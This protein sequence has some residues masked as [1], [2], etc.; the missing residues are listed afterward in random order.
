MTNSP[1]PA[2]NL[3]LEQISQDACL[4]QCARALQKHIGPGKSFSV[5]QAS[6]ALDYDDRTLRNNMAGQDLPRLKT[7]IRMCALFPGFADDMLWLADL[8]HVKPLKSEKI[9]DLTLNRRVAD[10]QA[11][12]AHDLE[13]DG[14]VDHRERARLVPQVQVL[15]DVLS[16]WVA[17]AMAQQVGHGL[18]EN[19]HSLHGSKVA[20]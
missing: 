2:R 9:P 4:K 19:V 11:L 8:G 6:A 10:L 7:F 17:H 18:A 1:V 14:H 20:A 12:L 15:I 16:R 13:T 5:A 3:Q